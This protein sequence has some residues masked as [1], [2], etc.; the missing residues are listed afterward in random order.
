MTKRAQQA[1]DYAEERFDDC[2]HP[3]E[4]HMLI[5]TPMRHDPEVLRVADEQTMPKYLRDVKE[6]LAL[7]RAYW[8]CFQYP[9]PMPPRDG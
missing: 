6:R 8:D 3:P 2:L 9:L 5:F 7:H 1:R 4:R